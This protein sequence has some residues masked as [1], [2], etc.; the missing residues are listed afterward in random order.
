MIVIIQLR[1]RKILA[2][3]SKVIEVVKQI[4]DKV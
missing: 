3:V 4:K 2:N 1:I